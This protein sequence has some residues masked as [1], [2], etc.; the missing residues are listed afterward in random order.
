MIRKHVA[1]RGGKTTFYVYVPSG[2][3]GGKKYI[4][5]T[6]SHSV[7]KDLESKAMGTE[8]HKL[9]RRELERARLEMSMARQYAH[10][11]NEVCPTCGGRKPP[12]W[13]L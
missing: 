8:E 7:A 4:G 5:K 3:R 2:N 13:S 12:E 6:S 9:G 11:A 1:K 10:W